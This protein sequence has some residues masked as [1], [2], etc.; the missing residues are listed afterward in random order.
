MY[1]GKLD[2][3]FENVDSNQSGMIEAQEL[4]SMFQKTFPSAKTHG[5][6]ALYLSAKMG[7]ERTG[8]ISRQAF[9]E[10][11]MNPVTHCKKGHVLKLEDPSCTCCN[12]VARAC[13]DCREVMRSNTVRYSCAICDYD[14]CESCR[15]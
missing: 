4:I 2:Q 8:R 10:V 6:Y 13:D 3:E 1:F 12:S 5:V 9:T 15:W 11:L 14:I 7:V